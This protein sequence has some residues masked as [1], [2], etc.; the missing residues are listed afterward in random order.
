M[1]EKLRLKEKGV[2]SEVEKI[3]QDWEDKWQET[4]NDRVEVVTQLKESDLQ[5][6]KIKSDLKSCRRELKK[7]SKELDD[8]K[9]VKDRDISNAKDDFED[10]MR[11]KQD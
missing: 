4:E 11:L 5:H 9:G 2:K 7:V 10:K 3:W 1:K 8:V 6:T